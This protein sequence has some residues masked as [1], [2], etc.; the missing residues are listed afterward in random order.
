MRIKSVI[1]LF[2]LLISQSVA[3]ANPLPADQAFEFS[4]NVD[5]HNVLLAKWKI[6]KG[7][8]LYKD[9]IQFKLIKGNG[10]LGV[11]ELPLGKT[12]RDK[13]LG[14]HEVYKNQLTV[15]VA[16]PNNP[17][18]KIQIAISY[19]GCQTD[20]YC[21][22]AEFKLM[23]L[24][25]SEGNTKV[26]IKTADATIF[27]DNSV[28][29]L[30]GHSS[31]VK[32]LLSFFGFGLL[33]AF[34][35]C[36]LPMIPI[37]SGIVIGQRHNLS[38][39]KAFS[40]SLTYVLAMAVTYSAA[41]V[42][43]GLAGENVQALLQNPWVLISFSIVFVLLSLSLFGYY[44]LKLPKSIEL[45]LNQLSHQQKGG[46][47]IGVALMGFFSAL[48]VSPCVSAPLIGALTYIA[49]TGDAVL[50]GLALF[51]LSMGMGLPLLVI[52]TTSGSL[53]PKAG[54]WMNQIKTFFGIL[55][56]GVAIYLL[57]RFLYPAITMYLWAAL[58]LGYAINLG[59]FASANTHTA[60]IS[61]WLGLGLALYAIMLVIGGYAGNVEPLK[62]LS[63]L[64]QPYVSSHD[65]FIKTVTT[66]TELSNELEQ[67]KNQKKPVLI[68]FTAE[69]CVYCKKMERT[70]FADE[71]V[72]K[73]IKEN[74]FAIRA[75]MTE[76][77]K[78]TEQVQKRL[79][80]LGLPA[81][82]FFTNQG[83]EL[84]QYRQSSSVTADELVPVMNA[85]LDR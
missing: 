4:A 80:V 48:V 28:V 46:T 42:A 2:F 27:D 36:V 73:L 81:I 54:P 1:I 57:S 67:A 33:L 72:R 29:A 68:D 16:L 31:L 85:V 74:F 5:Q 64:G 69:W 24:K 45:K 63:G 9:R 65:L 19:Q 59:A 66:P 55:L 6:A 34:T 12:I 35:P 47:Y 60:K 82:L 43:A 20:N 50:G 75:D 3:L 38:T 49:N 15:P 83:D 71:R 41:G 18:G 79:N 22:P 52:G 51:S 76:R 56:L 10:E 44:E 84:K 11:P 13:L 39:I 30:F 7:Y 26:S 40:L 62:P 61:K 58:G 21:Y 32:L 53:L 14:N 8:Y 70:T 17:S 77:N 78:D 25:F 37:I 23:E